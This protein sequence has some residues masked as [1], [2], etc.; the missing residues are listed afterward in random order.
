MYPD[1]S[2]PVIALAALQVVDGL[3]CVKPVA[4]IAACFDDVGFPT[5]WRWVFP[6]VKL[7]AAAGLLV[8]LVVPYLAAAATA[9]LVAYFVLAIGAHLRARDLGRNLFV[10]ATGMLAV[11]LG[12]LYASFA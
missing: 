9:G 1:P 7:A 6:V 4:F 3:L 12:V 2:W 8:G 11:C 10:N 5:R